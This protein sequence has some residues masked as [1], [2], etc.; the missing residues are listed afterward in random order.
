MPNIFSGGSLL[1]GHTVIAYYFS[2]EASSDYTTAPAG[3]TVGMNR[4]KSLGFTLSPTQP[5][6]PM[7]GNCLYHAIG[8]QILNS[9]NPI[10]FSNLIHE[11]DFTLN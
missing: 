5:S 9:S 10:N 11:I 7:D 6:T 4:I 8:L 3:W 2:A 1:P